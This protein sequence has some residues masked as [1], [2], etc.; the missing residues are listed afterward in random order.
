[1]Q[2]VRLRFNGSGIE[3][4]D[5]YTGVLTDVEHNNDHYK[6]MYFVAGYVHRIG[7][8]AIISTNGT[9]CWF[10]GGKRHR[11]DGPAIITGE[12]NVSW[13]ITGTQYSFE[14]WCDIL[15]I[16]D[17]EKLLLKLAYDF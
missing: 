17:E 13:W 11:E 3:C 10:Y 4:P 6:E 15:F 14:E 9:Q 7:G 5:I 12:G 16:Y 1:M 2:V 8:P